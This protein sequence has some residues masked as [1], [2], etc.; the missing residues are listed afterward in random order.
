MIY[1]VGGMRPADDQP[2]LVEHMQDQINYLRC[3]L[4]FGKRKP[5]NDH[6]IAA[7][8]E[9]IPELEP[10]SAPRESPTEASEK[11]GKVRTLGGA[12]ALVT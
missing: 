10:A 1:T 4:K 8:T 6:I 11:Q 3:S 9:R 12:E 2:Q 5:G 7:L